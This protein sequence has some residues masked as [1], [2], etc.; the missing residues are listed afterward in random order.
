M[1]GLRPCLFCLFRGGVQNS[2]KTAY[3]ILARSLC[4]T[5]RDTRHAEGGPVLVVNWV[6][7]IKKILEEKHEK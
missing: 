5:Y 1:G 7:D 3:I 6:A 4:Q 2:G